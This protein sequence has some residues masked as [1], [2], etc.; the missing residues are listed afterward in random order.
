MFLFQ[1]FQLG[2]AQAQAF[3]LFELIAEQLVA[4]ALL[5]AGVGESLQLLARLSPALRGKLYLSGQIG[6]ACVF[7]E[8]AAMGVGFQQGLVFMLAMDIDQQLAQGFQVAKGAGRAID[9]AA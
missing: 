4:S 8:Q 3:E 6:G 2:F 9:V 1:L 5:V 7:V